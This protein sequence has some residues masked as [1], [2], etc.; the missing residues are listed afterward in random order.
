[1]SKVRPKYVSFIKQTTPDYTT[2]KEKL[3]K[4]IIYPNSS[5]ISNIQLHRSRKKQNKWIFTKK[6]NK[7]TKTQTKVKQ[8]YWEENWNSWEFWY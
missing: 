6:E 1:M 2:V 3:R 5:L 8:I 4:L 7:Q